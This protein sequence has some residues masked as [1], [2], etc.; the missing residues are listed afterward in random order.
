MPVGGV[1]KSFIVFVCWSRA[2]TE[3][4]KL[5]H[6]DDRRNWQTMSINHIEEGT[7]EPKDDS[8]AEDDR[9]TLQ[10]GPLP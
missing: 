9:W 7:P 2:A 10:E 5:E 4:R 6:R 8:G 1:K 3:A